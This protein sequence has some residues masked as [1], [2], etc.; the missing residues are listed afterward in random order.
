M[1]KHYILLVSLVSDVIEFVGLV[2]HVFAVGD[3]VVIAKSDLVYIG[4]ERVVALS[5][6]QRQLF[7]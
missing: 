7:L 5:L 2:L 1:L 3:V 6:L 4:T